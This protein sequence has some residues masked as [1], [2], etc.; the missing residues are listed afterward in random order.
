MEAI[1]TFGPHSAKDVPDPLVKVLTPNNPNEWQEWRISQNLSDRWGEINYHNRDSKP[2]EFLESDEGLLDRLHEQ[3]W[4]EMTFIARKDGK[5]GIL[6]ECEY[7]SLESE[8]HE[9]ER[10]PDWYANLKP[11]A[12]VVKALL[13]GMKPLAKR[14]PG[15]LFAVP[16]ESEIFNGRPAAWAFVPDGSLTSEQREELGQALLSLC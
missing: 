12:Q 14:F 2:L 9:R 5:F 7:C 16:E 11:H 15:V 1:K 4:D 3:M 13:E 8:E 6:F 10:S